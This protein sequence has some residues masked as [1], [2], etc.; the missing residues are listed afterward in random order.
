MEGEVREAAERDFRLALEAAGHRYTSQRAAVYETLYA[1]S[2]HPTAAEIFTSVREHIPDISLATVY[3]ALEAFV[4]SGLA[5][6]LTLVGGPARYDG[7]VDEHQHIRCLDCGRVADIEQAGRP[8]WLRSLS[9]G[10]DFDVV[11]YRL[12]LVGTCPECRG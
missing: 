5:A 6:K 4:N 10:T 3:K 7:R 11:G 9:A 8:E 12:E 2:S 1:S